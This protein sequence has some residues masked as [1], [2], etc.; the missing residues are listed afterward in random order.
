VEAS[1][2][3]QET[4]DQFAPSRL[5][6]AQPDAVLCRLAVRGRSG[7][8]E[9]LYLRH[10]APLTAFIYHLL[11]RSAMAED[12]EDIVQD[13]FTRAFTGIR[14]KRADGSFKAWLYTIARNRAIDL[15]RT[16]HENVESLDA[17][18]STQP[19]APIAE[20]P[21][22]SAERRAELAWLVDAVADL[23]ERQREALL[24]R[25]MGGLSHE[26][27]AGQMGTTV[28][29]TKKLISRGRDGVEVAAIAAGHR[30]SRRQLGDQLALAVPVIPLTVSLASLGVG[31]GSTSALGK[32]GAALIAALALG[33]GLVAVE[34]RSGSGDAAVDG[35]AVGLQ[36]VGLT[37]AEAFF[38]TGEKT[39]GGRTPQRGDT[40]GSAADRDD[41][42]RGD[43]DSDSDDDRDRHDRHDDRHDDRDDDRDDDRSD[44]RGERASDDRDDD[45][46]RRTP[47]SDQRSKGRGDRSEREL[48]DDDDDAP[49]APDSDDD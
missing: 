48:D 13:A 22:E 12:A 27:I 43:D 9:A 1:P 3:Q 31:G 25:E 17:E 44:D 40:T 39:S 42:R 26:R 33:S 23:P 19:Q 47:A 14:E 38:T 41:D 4:A 35:A 28:S 37:P 24:M 16:R 34:L 15:M 18:D 29:A 20:Q 45:D 36:P 6:S 11:G 2:R 49:E 8:Y 32:T 10:A 7:A 46:A 30:T 21:A 5:M